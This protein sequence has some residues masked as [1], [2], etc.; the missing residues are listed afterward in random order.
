[1][2]CCCGW[3]CHYF[4]SCTSPALFI[5]WWRLW[6][7]LAPSVGAAQEKAVTQRAQLQ[8]CSHGMGNAGASQ[9]THKGSLWAA[10]CAQVGA[11]IIWIKRIPLCWSPAQASFFL[12]SIPHPAAFQRRQIARKIFGRLETD[13]SQLITGC[14]SFSNR[15]GLPSPIPAAKPE[16][17]LGL[18]KAGFGVPVSLLPHPL[19]WHWHPAGPVTQLSNWQEQ[20]FLPPSLPP[21]LAGCV[22]VTTSSHR[23]QNRAMAALQTSSCW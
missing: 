17:L 23:W 1:M 8:N 4:W 10:S 5:G 16:E 6:M 3:G 20:R 19:V 15:R 18:G 12:F 11:S 14:L 13:T 2:K 21:H 7:S 9:N 22:T